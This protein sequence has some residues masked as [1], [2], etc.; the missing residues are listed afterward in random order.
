M[1]NILKVL[2]RIILS[3]VTWRDW[4]RIDCS[5]LEIPMQTPET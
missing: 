1:I 3:I 4:D 2:N 5:C